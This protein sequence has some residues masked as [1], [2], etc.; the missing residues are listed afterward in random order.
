MAD[1]LTALPLF[2]LALTF[3]AF[4]IG[5]WCQKKTGSA[6]CN[7]ILVGAILVIAVLLITGI[8]PEVYERDTQGISWLLTPAT[9]CLALPLYQHIKVLKK[10]LPAILTGIVAGS[11]AGLICIFLMCKL[12]DLNNELTVSLL[13]KSITTAIGTAL[14]AQNGGNTALT[15]VVII[16]T[17]VFGNLIG[18]GF[19]KLLKLNDPIS[20]G[21]AFG[22]ASHLGGTSKATELGT[23]TGAVSSL[24]LVVAGIF[25]AVVF[26][27][28][29]TFL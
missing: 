10:D 24:S 26:P 2:S 9:V 7:P 29:C 5:A 17:G 11:L 19:S 16:I 1:F 6:L 8:D 25:T 15:S 23:I 27:I 21:V 18:T 14:S 3:C 22:T 13:P 4:Q 28:I 20:Q 12:F